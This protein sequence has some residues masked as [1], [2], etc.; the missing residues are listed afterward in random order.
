MHVLLRVHGTCPA[1]TDFRTLLGRAFSVL[2]LATPEERAEPGEPAVREFQRSIFKA[3][4][5]ANRLR[6]RQP[7]LHGRSFSAAI[8]DEDARAAAQS[9]ATVAEM[10]VS[11]GQTYDD[12]SS[13][14]LPR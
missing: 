14:P 8:S 12:G 6:N 10:L 7:A 4:C 13:G 5:A 2:G 3:A 9:I 11:A 1:S